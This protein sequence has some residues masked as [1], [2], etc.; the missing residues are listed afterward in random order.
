MVL[1]QSADPPAFRLGFSFSIFETILPLTL[2][3]VTF[4]FCASVLPAMKW[5]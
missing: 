1:W 5:A 2:S 3:K 4:S